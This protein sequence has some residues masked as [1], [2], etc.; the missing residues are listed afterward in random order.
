MLVLH[1]YF[2]IIDIAL[3]IASI[4]TTMLMQSLRLWSAAHALLVPLPRALKLSA[5][6]CSLSPASFIIA[7]GFFRF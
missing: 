6:S 4:N 2:F 5:I 1:S 3:S 7:Y